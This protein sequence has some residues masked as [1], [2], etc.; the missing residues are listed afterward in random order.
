MGS[1]AITGGKADTWKK[2]LV[3]EEAVRLMRQSA[4]AGE[5]GATRTLGDWYEDGVNG[6]PKDDVQAFSWYKRS[7]D[8]GDLT[9]MAKVGA[10]YCEGRGVATDVSRGAARLGRAAALGSEW[11]SYMLGHDHREGKFGFSKHAVEASFWYAELPGCTRMHGA[12][13]ALAEVAQ[14]LQARPVQ[15]TAL[16]ENNDT[17]VDYFLFRFGDDYRPSQRRRRLGARQLEVLP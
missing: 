13:I 14:G 16:P 7:A 3:Q 1:G 12:D 8:L 10:M 11:A 17:D 15:P 9:A 4:E 2:R 6:L 5:A